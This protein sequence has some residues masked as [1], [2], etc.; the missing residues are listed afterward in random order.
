MK[1]ERE[2]AFDK[3]AALEGDVAKWVEEDYLFDDQIVAAAAT[4]IS[5]SSPWLF[6]ESGIICARSPEGDL[7]KNSSGEKVINLR[8]WDKLSREQ[9][10]A[11]RHQNIRRDEWEKLPWT[12]HMCYLFTRAWEIGR[13]KSHYKRS[14]EFNKMK[15]VLDSVK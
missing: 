5:S 10:I 3:E 2:E 1:A 6:Y 14:R 11:F 15:D 13:L 4:S 8:E 9:R 7:R 12:G